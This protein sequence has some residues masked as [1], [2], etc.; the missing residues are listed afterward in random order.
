MENELKKLVAKD[1]KLSLDITKKIFFYGEKPTVNEGVL[2]PRP[3]TELLVENA[4]N[5]L[6]KEQKR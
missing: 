6:K 5:I 3:E 4:F 2:S 1:Y